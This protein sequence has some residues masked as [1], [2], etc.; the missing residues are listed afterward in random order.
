VSAALHGVPLVGDFESYDFAARDVSTSM[1]VMPPPAFPSREVPA[2]VIEKDPIMAVNPPQANQWFYIQ[3]PLSDS[4]GNTY[5]ANVSGASTNNG[6]SVIL[7]PLQPNSPNVLWTYTD[8]FIFSALQALGF[9]LDLGD[10]FNWNGVMGNYVVLNPYTGANSQQWT[11][12]DDGTISNQSNGLVLDI[13][14]GVAQAGAW[15]VVYPAVQGPP[16]WQQWSAALP[17]LFVSK[18][19]YLKSPLTDDQNNTYVATIQ[20]GTSNVVASPIQANSPNQLWQITLDGRILS[21]AEGNPVV[22][23][24]S[25][26]NWGPNGNN[27]VTGPSPIEVDNSLQWVFNDQNM[28]INASNGMALNVSGGVASPNTPLITYTAESGPPASETWSLS[29]A[30]PLIGILAAPPVSFPQFTG[31]QG[32]AYTD[33]CQAIGVSD[34][35]AQYTTLDNPF[36]DWLTVIRTMQCPANVQQPADWTFVVTELTAELI[37]VDAIQL[38][39][40]NY[41]TFHGDV[42][43]T[44]Q[45]LLT[46]LATAAGITEGSDTNV[47][48]IVLSVLENVAYTAL[49]AI[50]GAGAVLGNLMEAGINI[51]TSVVNDGG[52]IS[53]NPFQVAYYNLLSQLGDNF[54]VLLNTMGNME[55]TILSDWGMTKATYAAILSTGPDSLAWSADATSN[56]VTAG[57]TGYTISAMQMLMPAMYQIYQIQTNDNS[58]LPDVP[59]NT[60]WVQQVGESTY[61]KYWI[62]TPDNWNQFPASEAMDDHIWNV[63]VT[64][65]DF[66]QGLAG[67]GFARSYPTWESS[68][69]GTDCNGLVITITNLTP[70]PLTVAASPDSG[71]GKIIGTSSQTLQ[72][73]GSVSFV[74]YY[75]GVPGSS[76]GLAIDISILD[77]YLSQDRRAAFFTA[78]QHYCGVAAGDVWVDTQLMGLGYQL[79]P[80]ICN[81]GACEDSYPGAV[82]IGICMAPINPPPSN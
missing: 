25:Q 10:E 73:Y 43:V 29:P 5:V 4:I 45:N 81:S 21:A 15:M 8:G 6:T 39:F 75:T 66:F 12:N 51:A 7:W 24:G 74:G 33:I 1:R 71:Q 53:P 57:I 9:V 16:T 40:A 80:P 19:S 49:E 30:S 68:L 42:F 27:I 59:E 77:P 36:S 2:S 65:S 14:G 34:L 63:G 46:T 26:Y 20:D 37:A 38:L 58:A 28:F 56:L 22:T 67:W 60:Q 11:F 69:M 32:T 50:P 64:Y 61:N 23:L 44:N 55:T 41:A 72:P 79:T 52:A 48:G 54:V 17:P 62:A 31:D 3:S 76:G 82:Q 35:R 70:N 13:A 18:W 78:H 47:I